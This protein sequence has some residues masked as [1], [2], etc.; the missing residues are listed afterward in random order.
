MQV[1]RNEDV[2]SHIGLE[3]CVGR[4]EVVGEASAE[5]RAG[6]PLS[7][8]SHLSR[9]A[10][11]VGNAEGYTEERVFASAPSNSAGS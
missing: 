3:P 10:D 11:A 7:H 4:R 9:D 8:E 1:H 2:A 5:E 6:Q